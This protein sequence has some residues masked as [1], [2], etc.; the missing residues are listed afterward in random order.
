[1]LGV[2]PSVWSAL[3]RAPNPRTPGPRQSGLGAAWAGGSVH[4][5]WDWVSF[6]VPCHPNHSIPSFPCSSQIWHLLMLDPRLWVTP[7]APPASSLLVEFSRHCRQDGELPWE[8][9]LALCKAPACRSIF[10]KAAGGVF[11]VQNAA[12]T[13]SYGSHQTGNCC[14]H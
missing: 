7:Q 10:G 1:M 6:N 11:P 4:P 13:V 8:V 3:S 14:G 2:L 12:A 9:S 5:R